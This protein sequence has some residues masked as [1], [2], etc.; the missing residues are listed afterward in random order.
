MKTE[1]TIIGILVAG[2]AVLGLAGCTTT[3]GTLPRVTLL[4]PTD[5]FKMLKPKASV[6]QCRSE[7]LMVGPQGDMIDPAVRTLL[8]RDD[9][10]DALLNVVVESRA[11][12]VGVYGRRCVRVTG[13]V[14]RSVRSVLL[15]MPES[16]RGHHHD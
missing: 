7:G 5:G 1:R 11:W 14:V 9:E 16:H 4:A 15:P 12:S 3:L 10:G 6:T 8:A 2:L 13:D